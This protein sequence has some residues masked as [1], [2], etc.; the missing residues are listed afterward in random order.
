VSFLVPQ[1]LGEPSLTTTSD[2]KQACASV[3]APGGPYESYADQTM[4]T[5]RHGNFLTSYDLALRSPSWSAY[6]ITAEEADSVQGGRSSFK[7]DPDIPSDKQVDI[8]SPCWSETWN[9][10]HLAPSDIMSFDKATNGHWADTYYITNTALQYGPFNQHP[11]SMTEQHT[12]KWIKTNKRTLYIV[13]GT[14]FTGRKDQTEVDKFSRCDM[15]TGKKVDPDGRSIDDGTSLI[16]A[17]EV[18]AP[19]AAPSDTTTIK[20]RFLPPRSVVANQEQTQYIGVPDYYYKVLCDMDAKKSI[21]FLGHNRQ[22]DDV[23]EL[24]VAKLEADY[25]GLQLFPSE[26]CGTAQPVD[27]SYWPAP[28]SSPQVLGREGPEVVQ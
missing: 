15:S 5:C 23:K 20:A 9:R 14:I 26:E 7:T 21:A 11:W 18:I 4:L 22:D 12:L 28:G 3:L 2:A 1:S 13:T 8:H 27:S 6:M 16:A 19:S 17:D 25:L 24:T 10:G